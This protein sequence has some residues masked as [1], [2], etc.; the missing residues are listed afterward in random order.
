MATRKI[1]TPAEEHEIIS[2]RLAGETVR[3]VATAV[4][5]N[6]STVQTIYKRFL[7]GETE[8]LSEEREAERTHLILR[9]QQLA[10]TAQRQIVAELAEAEPNPQAIGRYMAEERQAL[11]EIARVT[12][13]DAPT[14]VEHSGGVTV[15][16][17]DAEIARLEA[18]L[19]DGD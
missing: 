6:P 13:A 1:L 5:R 19:N 17:V 4:R 10:D 9:Y 12:G 16:T 8:R 3:D 7:D 14:K 18:E 2:R 15:E 11:R